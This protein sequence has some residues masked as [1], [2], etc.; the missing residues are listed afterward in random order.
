MAPFFQRNQVYDWPPFS[1]KSIW[2][3]RFF[4]I[5][6][7]KTQLFW[8]PGI[9]TYFS[10]IDFSRLLVLWV[11]N[12]LTA[13]KSW[14]QK[15]KGR[16]M[17][18]STFRMFKY[19]F[20]GQVYEWGRFWNTGSHTYTTITPLPPYPT[21]TTPTRVSVVKQWNRIKDTKTAIGSDKNDKK[22]KQKKKTKKNKKKKKTSAEMTRANLGLV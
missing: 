19:I 12:E 20:K 9:C 21:P 3:T 14:V 7:W 1:T 16:Y 5:P 6:M 11:Y 4:W 8:H 10:L 15:A 17:N 22:T 2:M 18:W 13:S